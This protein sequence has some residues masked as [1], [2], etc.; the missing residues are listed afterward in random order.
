LSKALDNGFALPGRQRRKPKLAALLLMLRKKPRNLT[1]HHLP[2]L[3]T[4]P[5][6]RQGVKCFEVA[7]RSGVLLAGLRKLALCGGSVYT[8]L[9]PTTW[10]RLALGF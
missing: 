9:L 1:F 6:T 4:L 7:S 3:T 5:P 2:S 10:D 8:A